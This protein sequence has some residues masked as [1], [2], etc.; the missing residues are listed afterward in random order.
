MSD[1]WRCAICGRTFL[2]IEARFANLDE[3]CRVRNM[4]CAP[5]MLITI[6]SA[7]MC[8]PLVVEVDGGGE[9]E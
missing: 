5:C 8:K 4:M 3:E 7:W 1:P 2:P 6:G 9:G